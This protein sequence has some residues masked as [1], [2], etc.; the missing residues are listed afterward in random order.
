[1][2]PPRG[3]SARV[4]RIS[5]RQGPHPHP[6][7]RARGRG[8]LSGGLRKRR[9]RRRAVTAIAQLH[10]RLEGL[11]L[12]AIDA[13]LEALLEQAA[14]AEP[15]YADFLLDVVNAEADARR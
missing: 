2:R 13:R 10:Q 8:A 3:H 7:R 9:R 12:T 4:Y 5:E 15:A 1:Q 11:G 14:K 6:S